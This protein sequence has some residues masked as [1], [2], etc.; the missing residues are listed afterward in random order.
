M[1]VDGLVLAA[2]DVRLIIIRRGDDLAILDEKAA[3]IAAKA[4]I[5]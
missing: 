2:E 3:C 1:A 5:I 4:V